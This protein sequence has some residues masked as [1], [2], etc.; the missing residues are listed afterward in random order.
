MRARWTAFALGAC[1]ALG[2]TGLVVTPN[3]VASTARVAAYVAGLGTGPGYCAGAGGFTLRGSPSIDDV[4]PC[5]PLPLNNGEYGPGIPTFWPG[6]ASSHAAGGFQ[7][8]E[9]AQ[10]FL[11]VRSHGDLNP[12]GDLSG[13]SFANIAAGRF[14][15]TVTSSTSGSLPAV[16]DIISEAASS[17]DANTN[18]GGPGDV[19]VVTSV[20]GGKIEI[21]GEN[22]TS[23]GYNYITINGPT[24]WVIN[25]KSQYQY[26]YFQWFNPAQ[27]VSPT[28]GQPY[29][30]AFQANTQYMYV[31]G[32]AEKANT[33]QGMKAGT[34]PAIAQLPTG[35]YEEA[36]QANTGALI[37]VGSGGNINTHLPMMP[38]TSPAIAAAPNG[39]FEV[40]YQSTNGDL[41]TYSRSA[42]A[43]NLKQGMK[44]GTSPAIAY[45]P[46]ADGY[47]EAFQANTGYLLDVGAA[48]N[49]DTLQGMMAGTSPS[50]AAAPSGGFK[51]AF[52]ANTGYLYTA[53]SPPGGAVNLMQ[54]MK[55]GTS[56]SI[57][58]VAGAGYEVAFQAN[59][60]YLL[61]IG[62]AGNVNTRQGMMAGTSPAITASPGGGYVAAFQANTGNLYT[63]ASAGGPAN[64]QQGMKAGTSPAIAP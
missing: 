57:T 41:Y 20:G 4:Y 35:G 31:F 25:P 1:V 17:Y 29:E 50:I 61:A 54:G 8:T 51:D 43:V 5:G 23:N 60:G 14:H 9:F 38:G 24:N 58:Y 33:L 47:E 18:S 55:P 16:G 42:G 40:A 64:L 2:F 30:A 13:Q 52:Q 21:L 26:T 53:A 39:T 19:A 15:F 63:Y 22:D 27:F 32:T 56:P 45:V 3:V 34:N 62:A 10:R 28:I 11:Y 49:V 44:A 46:A 48:G 36:F 12:F 59:T 7:C 6:S 37:V